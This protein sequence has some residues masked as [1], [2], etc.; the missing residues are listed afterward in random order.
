MSSHKIVYLIVE[1]GDRHTGQTRWTQAGSAY[2]CRD[3]SFNLRLDMFPNLTFNVRN[4]KSN[5]E[6]RDAVNS[7]VPQ[8]IPE[9]G[10]PYRE[11]DP[12]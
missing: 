1:R 3:G 12:F 5:G 11:G 2:E 4:P 6:L 10:S 9:E 8:R 7:D